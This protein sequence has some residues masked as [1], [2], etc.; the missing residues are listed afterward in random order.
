MGKV[1]YLT[2]RSLIIISLIIILHKLSYASDILEL[3]KKDSLIID[4]N[5]GFIACNGMEYVISVGVAEKDSNDKTEMLK[6]YRIAKLISEQNLSEFVN[7][8]KLSSTRNLE[9]EKS[10]VSNNLP[11]KSVK[12]EEKIRTVNTGELKFEHLGSWYDDGRKN[13]FF[14]I[15]IKLD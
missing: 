3:I 11:I 13:C 1:N 14:A 6:C 4:G 15:G 8:T 12:L 10:Q 2:L 7:F 9:I 5:V